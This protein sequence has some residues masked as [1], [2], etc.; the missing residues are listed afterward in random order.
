MALLA[1]AALTL[2][3]AACSTTA[4][5]QEPAAGA[6][7]AFEHAEPALSEIVVTGTRVRRDDYSAASAAQT[8]TA[9]DIERLGLVSV[10]DMLAQLPSN[11]GTFELASDGSSFL[12]GATLA[13]LRGI[14]AAQ[15]TRTL[16]LVDG[17]RQVQTTGGGS[18]DRN[19][20]PL[21]LVSRM[22]TVAGGASAVYGSD[23][24]AGVVNVLVDID[25]RSAGPLTRVQPGEEIWI[26]ARPK[27]PAGED[28]AS[29]GAGAMVATVHPSDMPDA[30]PREVPLPLEHTDVRAAVIG[31]VGTVDVTQ[32]FTNPFDEKIEAVY[33][34]PLPEQAAVSEF[35]MTIGERRIRGILREREEAEAVYRQARAQG[36]Q[37]SL[38]TQ[39]RPNV[40]EQ[41]VAN[42]EP[43]K[44]IDV[45]IRYYH[46]LAYGDGWYSFV[47]PMVVGPRYNPAGSTDPLLALPR[48]DVRETGA[49]AVRYLR[50][51]ERSGHDIG[52]SVDLA[53][54]VAIEEVAASH[55]IKQ[56]PLDGG[57]MRVTLDEL[58]TIPN[59][60]F[61]LSFR[62]AGEKI[63]SNLLTYV[64]P[65]TQQGYFTL[66]LYPPQALENL[67]RQPLELV[68]V[69]DCSGSMSGQPLAQAKA[70]LL[71]ALD[72][73]TPRDTF[74]IIRFSN[75]AS[76]FGAEPV[77]AT[78]DNVA[79]ARSYV[80]SLSTG[81]GTEMIEGV[82]AALDFPHDPK[83]LRFVTFM[84]DGY[85][86]NEA[87]ILREI[88]ARL[89]ASRIFSFGVGSSVNRYLIE[90]MAGVGRGVVAYL[91]LDDSGS[92]VMNLFFDRV[93]HPALV[94]VEIDWGGMQVADVYPARLPDLFVGRPVVVTGKFDGDAESPRVRGNA[95]GRR[96]AFSIDD[97]ADAPAPTF[98]P[99]I[100]ARLRIADLMDQRARTRDP[101]GEIGSAIRATALTYG[102]MSDYT[103]F[104]AVDASYVTEGGH[105]TTVHQAVPVPVGVRYDTT[106]Q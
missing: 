77:L 78:R 39:H 3:V 45:E 18:V 97:D 2:L 99:N 102:L 12:V 17:R 69:V 104:V 90:R 84:T 8:V 51:N 38:L 58:A 30:P 100:W 95:A 57:A 66:M 76:R 29:P 65:K 48:T 22:D 73:L 105:G 44:R 37:A 70:A 49:A 93:S 82:K 101:Q 7:A 31:Y 98:L 19:M 11:L 35:V 26:I 94:D 62:V 42:I 61:V 89:G 59:Q 92:D 63:K 28:D 23:A 34:F 74:Q 80:Q 33:L 41:K 55:R 53:P 24:M 32:Q 10:A 64:D 96:V 67:D 9:E 91:G 25:E 6:E 79:A 4:P 81:G 16:V 83:R 71:A 20:I 87:D 14:N 27:V 15:G 56:E 21:P 103:S 5:V 86:G 36:Y 106:V 13:N 72:R 54:G 88:D 52:I 40:F 75:E 46:T 1:G 47:F 85:I 43:G 60:D 50:P 68:F